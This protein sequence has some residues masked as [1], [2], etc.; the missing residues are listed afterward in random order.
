[1][2]F[3]NTTNQLAFFIRP[4][5]MDNGQEVLPCYWS[6]NYFSLAPGESMNVNVSASTAQLK[7]KKVEVQ[8][9]GW[10]IKTQT[11]LLKGN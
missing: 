10:N 9:D 2:K 3:T 7:S 6:A 11:I 1:M 5:L 4:Q 8:V